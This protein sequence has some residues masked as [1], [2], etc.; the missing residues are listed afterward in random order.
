[1]ASLAGVVGSNSSEDIDIGFLKLLFIICDVPVHR[2]K[3]FY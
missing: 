3:G 1:M 2:P